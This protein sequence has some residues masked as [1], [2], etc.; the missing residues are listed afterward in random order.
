[1]NR[2]TAPK[3]AV[4]LKA[5]LTKQANQPQDAYIWPG[6]QMVCCQEGRRGNLYNGGW[7]TVLAVDHSKFRLKG[8]DGKKFEISAQDGMAKLRMSYALTYACCQ[9]LTLRGL[10]RLYDCDH[11]RMDWR[12]L[13]V[14]I[15]R[16]TS[17]E[18]VEVA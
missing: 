10:V 1:M 18:N 16:A 9:G 5:P 14:G 13:N 12:K 11:P 7:F 6:M 15:S 8:E 2:L 3:D 4:Y 17:G